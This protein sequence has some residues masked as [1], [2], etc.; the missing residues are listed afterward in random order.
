MTSNFDFDHIYD[1]SAFNSTKWSKYGDRDVLPFWVADMDFPV[2]KFLRDAISERMEHPIL[3]YTDVGDELN[4]AFVSWLQRRYDWQ[5]EPD[6][7]VWVSSIVQAMNVAVKVVGQPGDESLVMVPVYPPFLKMPENGFRAL[8]TS[9]LQCIESRWVMDYDDL[10]EKT[11]TASSLLFSNPQNPTGRVYT[12]AELQQLSDICLEH[13]VI[14]LSDEIHWGVV[15]EPGCKHQPIASLAPEIANQTVTFF[16]HT[17]T[18]NISGLPSAVVIIPNEDIRS[19]FEIA[20]YGLAHNISPLALS[21]TLAAYNDRSSWL[22]EL[23][24]YLRKNRNLLQAAVNQTQ[25]LSMTNIEGT[26]LGWID[27]R[28]IPV[29]DK[30]AYFEAFGLGLSN[31]SDFCRDGFVRFNFAA[32][33][34]L[35]SQG[36]ERLVEAADHVCL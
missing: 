22:D 16:S 2:P 17:K 26:H 29:E 23:K 35:V 36:L 27:A 28:A 25:T 31:G 24:V 3:G 11:K 21:A 5:I 15:L 8:T 32:P 10:N 1:R 20:R 18:Y 19:A 12:K 13:N 30:A 4:S 7:L 34:K 6:W 33:T 9:R 14:I